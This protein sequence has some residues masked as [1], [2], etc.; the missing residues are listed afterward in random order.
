MGGYVFL[1]CMFF[2]PYLPGIFPDPPPPLS[3]LA[4]FHLLG[5]HF[6]ISATAAAGLSKRY[7]VSRV[8]TL[9]ILRIFW[10]F[11][12]VNPRELLL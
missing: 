4:I 6:G 8:E 1:P 9:A 7:K 11:A 5:P 3:K 2:V 12:K 10:S